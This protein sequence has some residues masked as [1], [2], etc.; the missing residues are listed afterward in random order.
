MRYQKTYLVLLLLLPVFI[1]SAFAEEYDLHYFLDKASSKEIVISKTEQTELLDRIEQVIQKADRTRAKLTQIIQAG[2]IDVRYQE[3]KFWMSKLEEDRVSIETATQQIKLLRDKPTLLV[4]SIK[5]YKSLKDLSSNFNA[6][7]NMSSFS[8]LVG[9]LAPEMELW[10]DPVLYQL[11][12]LP[13]ARSRDRDMES[14]PPSKE[15]KPP[16][17]ETKEKKPVPKG[18]KP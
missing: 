11:N 18:K 4:S 3:G 7:N 12:L 6:Y 8:A 2:E 14:K 10:T 13:L 16:L 5:L 1:S 17:K 9:D 15:T